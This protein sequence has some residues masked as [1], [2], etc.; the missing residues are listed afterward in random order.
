MNIARRPLLKSSYQALSFPLIRHFH[1]TISKMSVQTPP[2]L[3]P[4][5]VS[6]IQHS[7][8]ETLDK[9]ST[10][11]KT[12]DS[13]LTHPVRLVAV[14]KTKPV[15][16]LWAAYQAGQRHF[17]ENVSLYVQE[18]VEKAAVLPKDINWHFIGTL[19]SNKC[20]LLAGI[21]NLWAVETIDGIKK[22]DAMN[23][24]WTNSTSP[25]N[26][27]LQVNTS[28]ESSKSGVDPAETEAAVAHIRSAC[29]NLHL[30]G[31]MTIGSIDHS[32]SADANPDFKVLSDLASRLGGEK[33]LELS[34]GMSG[35]FEAAIR[36][37]S[38]NV[39]VGSGIFG[40]RSYPTKTT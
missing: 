20:K 27:F 39:R 28:G 6:D 34:M 21:S 33:P 14:S 17:G 7:L 24:A 25:L 29:P 12:R 26:V 16:D 40:A 11:S 3:D 32:A 1:T 36:A 13:T 5:R 37:G 15:E 10:V 22:A 4:S 38:W 9:I 23:K 35:D 30:R 31:L 19:Q 2:Q 8:A 18:L